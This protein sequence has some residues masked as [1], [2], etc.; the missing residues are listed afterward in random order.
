MKT[1]KNKVRVKN[2]SRK[3]KKVE[4]KEV[5]QAT[6]VKLHTFTIEVK[7]LELHIETTIVNNEVCLFDDDVFNI[8]SKDDAKAAAK[9]LDAAIA[10]YFEIDKVY[11]L[12]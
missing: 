9:T 1:A 2:T 6:T 12:L 8:L 5:E 10:K 3:V 4:V 7:K 11:D